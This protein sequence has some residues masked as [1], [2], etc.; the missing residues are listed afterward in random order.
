MPA[1][2]NI[3]SEHKGSRPL[4]EL[5]TKTILLECIFRRSPRQLR[6]NHRLSGRIMQRVVLC[7][8]SYYAA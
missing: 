1:G 3:C 8:G 6:P 7:S 5:R 2:N 4:P